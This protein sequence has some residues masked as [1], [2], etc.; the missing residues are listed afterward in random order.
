MLIKETVETYKP[1]W[2][3]QKKCTR[4]RTPYYYDDEE[5]IGGY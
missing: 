5:R 1:E 2:R 3:R 4:R